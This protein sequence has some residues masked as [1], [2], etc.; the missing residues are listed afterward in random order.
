M[1]SEKL[2]LLILLTG[3]VV[4]LCTECG[5]WYVLDDPKV[6]RS[7]ARFGHSAVVHDNKMYIFGGFNGIVLG[8]MFVYEPGESSSVIVWCVMCVMYSLIQL[9]MHNNNNNNN[10]AESQFLRICKRAII[11]TF[12]Y[13]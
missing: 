2:W 3:D 8:D 1:Q 12:A 9:I 10:N 13:K 11:S 5:E 4:I 7:I 6:R